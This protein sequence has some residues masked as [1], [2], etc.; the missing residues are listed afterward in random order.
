MIDGDLAR[1]SV[2]VAEDLCRRI[3]REGRRLLVVLREVP[4]VDESGRQL[5]ERLARHGARLRGVGV[6]TS[7]LVERVSR[8]GPRE[9]GLGTPVGLDCP[10][11]Q[12]AEAPAPPRDGVAG[13]TR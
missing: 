13:T 3:L 12:A 4:A 1:G 10:G 2:G 8:R 11:E 5:L 9:A 7:Y 6:Y